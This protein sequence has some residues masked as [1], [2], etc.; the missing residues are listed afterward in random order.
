VQGQDGL[1][2]YRGKCCNPIRG[3]EIVGYITRGKGISVHTA[4]CPN[5]IKF[6]GSDRLTDVEWVENRAGE[7]FSVSLKILLEDRQG[8][9]AEVTSAISNLET[10]IRE[11][12]SSSDSDSGRGVV[13]ITVD[14]SDIAHL[15]KVIRRLKSIS[16]VQDVERVNHI[17]QF[18]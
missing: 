9:L 16:G 5:A 4:N 13:E 11:S 3:D 6:L 7:F 17:P 18:E 2:V 12:R 14:I 8:I 15:Q 10:N 1:L